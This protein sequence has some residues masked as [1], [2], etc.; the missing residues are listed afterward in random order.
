M[1]A[2]SLLSSSGRT[3][4]VKCI[5]VELMPFLHFLVPDYRNFGV[6][7]WRKVELFT[8]L[9]DFCGVTQLTGDFDFLGD[10]FYFSDDFNFSGDF[11]FSGY[12]DCRDDF[13]F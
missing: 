1:L 8:A 11:D 5:A 9:V 12:F 10:Y 13:D 6:L 4:L 3:S 7:N 2:S